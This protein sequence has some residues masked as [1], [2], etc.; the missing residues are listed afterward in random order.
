MGLHIATEGPVSW[1]ENL[2]S[3]GSWD[4][5]LREFIPSLALAPSI[6]TFIKEAVLFANTQSTN[7]GFVA[8]KQEI[9]ET[10]IIYIFQDFFKKNK[11]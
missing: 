1:C 11:H 10:L 8:S 3:K 6:P 4:G 9:P 7:T 2:Q 5:F